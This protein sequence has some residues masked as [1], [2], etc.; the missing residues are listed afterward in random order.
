SPEP[1]TVTRMTRCGTELARRERAAC[2]GARAT[3]WPLE[4]WRASTAIDPIFTRACVHWPEV[5]CSV[6][7]RLCPLPGAVLA[8]LRRSPTLLLLLLRRQ[9]FEATLE[10]VEHVLHAPGAHRDILERPGER[11]ALLLQVPHLALEILHDLGALDHEIT[12]AGLYEP[13]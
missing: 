6:R 10:L 5:S 8:A 9:A 7:S 3:A 12:R 4:P 11:V 2:R 1:S 13:D